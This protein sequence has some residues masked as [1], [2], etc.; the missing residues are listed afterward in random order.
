MSASYE[1]LI[2]SELENRWEETKTMC[3]SPKHAKVLRYGENPPKSMALSA[4][5]NG[6]SEAEAFARKNIYNNILDTDA[7]WSVVKDL[8]KLS[9]DSKFERR[10]SYSSVVVK[11][12]NPYGL[13]T[14]SSKLESIKMS[15]KSDLFQ[16][17]VLL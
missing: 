15:F 16:L 6:L 12:S 11:H 10:F 4:R 13:A 5:N 9:L 17:L 1:G 8:N 14:A 7:A 2:A 3:L